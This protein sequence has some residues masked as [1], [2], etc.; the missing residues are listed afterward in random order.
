MLKLSLV[1]MCAYCETQEIRN[2][3]IWSDTGKNAGGQ[4]YLHQ[5]LIG[6]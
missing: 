6:D 2:I 3:I 1:E 5:E 4:Q